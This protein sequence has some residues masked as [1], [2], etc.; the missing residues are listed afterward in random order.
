MYHLE[1]L[2]LNF[3]RNDL[4]LCST[5]TP[6]FLPLYPTHV[7]RQRSLSLYISTLYSGSPYIKPLYPTTFIKYYFPYLFIIYYHFFS[8]IKY[9]CALKPRQGSSTTLPFIWRCTVLTA[10]TV[11]RGTVSATA[12]EGKVG[13]H[14]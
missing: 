5:V 3:H 8:T 4:R 6:K 9:M 1:T 2:L 14:H 13:G 11:A 12:R 7:T 10:S